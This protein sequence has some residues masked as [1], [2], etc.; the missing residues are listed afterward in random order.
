VPPRIEP[1]LELTGALDPQ[2]LDLQEQMREQALYLKCFDVK[3]AQPGVLLMDLSDA[4][5]RDAIGGRSATPAHHRHHP[6]ESL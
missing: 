2:L 6:L 1:R 4:A 3:T 5:P